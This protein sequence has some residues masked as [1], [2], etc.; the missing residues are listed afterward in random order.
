MH[1]GMKK[2]LRYFA[3]IVLTLFGLV[4]LFM[5]ASVIFDLFG[6]REKQGDFVLFVVWANLVCSILY[7]IAAYGILTLKKWPP[8]LM[9]VAATL[10]VIAFLGLLYHINHGGAYETK[11]IGALIFRSVFTVIFIVLAHYIVK[12]KRLPV[13]GYSPK[14]KP[15][16]E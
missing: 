2:T 12:N 3:T 1:H 6:I 10:L 8:T 11:T 15:K 7:L 13:R 4:T 16:T 9:L 14:G 5:S